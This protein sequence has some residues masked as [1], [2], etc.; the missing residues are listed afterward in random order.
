[1]N[2]DENGMV[3]ID[4]IDPTFLY[5]WKG[6]RHEDEAVYHSHDHLEMAFVLSGIGKYRGCYPA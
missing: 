2:L 4:E 1:M 5:I 6:T 3:M